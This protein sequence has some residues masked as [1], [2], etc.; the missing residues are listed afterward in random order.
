M[1]P[2][3]Q[4]SSINIFGRPHWEIGIFSRNVKFKTKLELMKINEQNDFSYLELAA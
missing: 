4:G 1:Y 3:H 2:K